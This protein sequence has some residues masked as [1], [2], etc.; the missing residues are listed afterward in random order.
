MSAKNGQF[1]FTPKPMYCNMENAVRAI[2]CCVMA[3][4]SSINL[5]ERD[6][7]K[8][9]VKYLTGSILVTEKNV[10]IAPS[11]L[12]F[13]MKTLLLLLVPNAME[14]T[15]SVELFLEINQLHNIDFLVI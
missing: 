11:R 9:I 10:K 7:K 12:L 14:K 8:S 13:Q 5:I 6:I 3:S 1:E 2:Q 15:T 4:L